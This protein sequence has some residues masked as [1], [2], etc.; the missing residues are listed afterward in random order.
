MLGQIRLKTA[1]YNGCHNIE[2]GYFPYMILFSHQFQNSYFIVLKV[3][4]M[5]ICLAWLWFGFEILI[6][7][8]SIKRMDGKS[9]L[10]NIL[11]IFLYLPRERERKLD[12]SHCYLCPPRVFQLKSHSH[13]RP[14]TSRCQ[15]WGFSCQQPPFFPTTLKWREDLWWAFIHW[16]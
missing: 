12:H 6:K 14:P 1:Q 9:C 16:F 10:G 11:Y 7:E 13:P 2:I 3:I 15:V 5:H 8:N 4:E